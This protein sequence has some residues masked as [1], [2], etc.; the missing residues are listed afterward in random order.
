[1]GAWRVA[2]CPPSRATA[3]H[4]R[5]AA[6]PFVIVKSQA[7]HAKPSQQP[8]RLY[9]VSRGEPSPQ[10]TNRTA[11]SQ[12]TKPKNPTAKARPS[13][14]PPNQQPP[15]PT[16]PKAN[17]PKLFFFVVGKKWESGQRV[18]IIPI[19]IF[20]LLFIPILHY[21]KNCIIV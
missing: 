4:T 5:A 9:E 16:K 20:S 10:P 14:Q 11:P 18:G 8:R 12:P 6:L 19:R 15:K 13:Q 1:M 21:Y 2:L 3:S 7:R 17:A